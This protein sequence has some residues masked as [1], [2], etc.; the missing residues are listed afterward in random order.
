[1]YKTLLAAAALLATGGSRAAASPEA[2]PD[3]SADRFLI[4]KWSCDQTRAGRKTGREAVLYSFDLDG[5]W[6]RL[7]Y[8]LTPN[9]SDS[10]STKTTAYETFD[11]SLGKWVYI[12]MSSD[13]DYGISYSAGWKGNIKEYGPPADF[14]QEWRLIATKLS[15]NE[16]SEDIEALESDGGWHRTVSLACRRVVPR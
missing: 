1:M 10:P 5:R 9:Q 6:L 4:G 15:D 14:P 3:W 2:P 8:T 12:S 11:S 16:F 7:A 13:G